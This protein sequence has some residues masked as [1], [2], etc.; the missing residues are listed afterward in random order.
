MP[1]LDSSLEHA[2]FRRRWL[3]MEVPWANSITQFKRQHIQQIA[4]IRWH[5]L[6]IKRSVILHLRRC[7]DRHH[8]FW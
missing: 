6:T 3:L 7:C 2:T 8:A 5:K 4:I 1:H